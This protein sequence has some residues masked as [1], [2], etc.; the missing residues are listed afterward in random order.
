MGVHNERQ[1]SRRD[2]CEYPDDF[3]GLHGYRSG[4]NAN[5][6]P[7]SLGYKKNEKNEKKLQLVG[8]EC[9]KV[10]GAGIGSALAFQH[11]RDISTSDDR[12]EQP[13]RATQ[14]TIARLV[15]HSSIADD[16]IVH[17]KFKHAHCVADWPYAPL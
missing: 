7:S 14:L 2:R 10:F 8:A 13:S 12:A 3:C 5:E 6:N 15:S 11:A 17:E 1:G 9:A 16:R 4:C